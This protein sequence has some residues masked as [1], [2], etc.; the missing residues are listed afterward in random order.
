MKMMKAIRLYGPRD[1][2]LEEVPC[3]ASPERGEV[4]VR[5]RSVGI[6]GS[7]L[8]T[9]RHARIGDTVCTTPFIMGHEFSGVVQVVGEGPTGGDGL[10]VHPGDR[11][12][13]DPAQP[14]GVCELCKKGH[15]NLCPHL[16]FL[17][18]Y[19]HDGS[20]CEWIRVPARNCFRVPDLIDDEEAALLEPLGVALHSVSLPRVKPGDSAAVIGAG[21]IGLCVLQVL[22]G[23]GIDPVFVMEKLPWRSKL[24]GRLGASVVSGSDAQGV[25]EVLDRTAGRGVDVAF[26]A[27][28]SDNSVQHCAEIVRP[29]GKLMVIG[30]S[31]DDKLYLKHSTARR[32][33]ITILMVRRMKHTYPDA[34]DLVLRRIV[35]LKTLITHRF[36]LEQTPDAFALNAA[37]D[38]GIAK[39][40]IQV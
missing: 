10:L 11:V 29:G 33:G 20:L 32:K 2:R 21:P 7:D 38:D 6:C 9:F 8:H 39:A 13:V 5:V 15:S 16:R 28:W 27:A 19:P 1:L 12:A 31:D 30:I 37:Y 36:R 34:I 4:L 26:E 3:P 14:C 40:I 18:H 35:D 24:A 17:G 22:K 23:V 25:Q